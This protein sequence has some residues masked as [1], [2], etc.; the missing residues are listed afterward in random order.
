MN[1]YP[2]YMGLMTFNQ[3]LLIN[4]FSIIVNIRY[5]INLVVGTLSFDLG[6]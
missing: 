5:S 2:L 6:L 1:E 4:R 3:C